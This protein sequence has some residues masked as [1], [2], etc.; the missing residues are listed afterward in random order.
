MRGFNHLCMLIETDCM[1]AGRVCRLLMFG[2]KKD[3]R[4]DIFISCRY[5][6][7][8]RTARTFYDRLVRKGYSVF[9]DEKKRMDDSCGTAPLDVIEQCRD[10]ILILSPNSLDR[11]SDEN[12]WLRVE[13]L[14]AV[15]HGKNIIPV[16]ERDFSFPE[17]NTM[18]EALNRLFRYHGVRFS[19]NYFDA[20]FTALLDLL[21]TPELFDLLHTH[22]PIPRIALFFFLL[23]LLQGIYIYRL[24][25]D[26]DNA[27][28]GIDE[29]EQIRSVQST[30]SHDIEVSYSSLEIE[31]ALMDAPSEI[32]GTYSPKTSRKRIEAQIVEVEDI[33][34]SLKAKLGELDSGDKGG[35]IS[36]SEKD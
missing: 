32:S 22:K 28:N 19:R 5:D 24:T 16:F 17:S 31:E 3:D 7:G 2:N 21:K 25:Y 10:F 20:A 13:I 9:L 26:S 36:I 8:Y 29:P 6:N 18:P 35:Q 30:H 12:D 14:H 27:G 33:L 1:A 11:C 4:C 34:A 23:S 15:K